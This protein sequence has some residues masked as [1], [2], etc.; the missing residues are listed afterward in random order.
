TII[1]TTRSTEYAY[2]YSVDWGDGSEIE[3]NLTAD[4]SHTYDEPGTYKVTISGT[5]PQTYFEYNNSD[6]TKLV[7]IVKWGDIAWRSMY[8]AF[9]QAENMVSTASDRPDI[10]LVTDMERAFGLATLFN[11]DIRDWDVSNVTTLKSTFEETEQFNQDISD[12]DVSK[13]TSMI[14]TFSGA[15]AFNQPVGKWNM[16]NVTNTRYMFQGTDTFN[17]PLNDWDMSKVENMEYMFARTKAFNQPLDQ[18]DV[19]SVTIMN[20]LF[21]QSV[22]NQPIGS[23]DIS[24]VESLYALFRDSPFD[25]DISAWQVSQVTG[26]HELFR[27]SALSTTH[28]DAVLNAWSQQNVVDGVKFG[29]DNVQ[30][31]SAAKAAHKKLFDDHAWIITDGGCTDCTP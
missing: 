31:S 15:K 23:W 11:G 14:G 9:Y 6:N 21:F 25:Q 1:I 19:S 26:F 22:F 8:Y 16:S 10:R 7:E 28:Y 29:A 30:Y 13:V 18:W 4:A 3:E 27:D 20:V 17:Q 12:W 24:G 5:F 2:N